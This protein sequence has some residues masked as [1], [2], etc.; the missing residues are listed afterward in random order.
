MAR[1]VRR[2]LA[3]RKATATV[4]LSTAVRYKL[5]RMLVKGAGF[6]IVPAWVVATFF[7]PSFRALTK[8]GYQKN[9][10]FFACVSALAFAFPEP[11]LMVYEDES[12]GAKPVPNHPIR[13][14]L[15]K[16]NPRMSERKLAVRTI[17]YLAIGGNC[18]LHKVRDRRG[19]V[20]ELWPYHTGQMWPVPGGPEW[21]KGYEFDDG[22]GNLQSVPIEDV[23]H[24]QWPSVDPLQPWVAQAPLMAAAREVDSDNETTRYLK[25]ILQ[26]DAVPRGVLEMPSDSALNPAEIN[27]V[28]N[29]FSERYGGDNR[30]QVLVLEGG[31]KYSRIALNLEELAFDAL[32]KIPETR[33]AAVMR[34]PAIVAGISAGLDR[35]TYANYSEARQVFTQDTLVPLWS[36]V[37]DEIQSGLAA[38]FGNGIALRHDLG[39]V[40]ALQKDMDKLWARVI[41]GFEKGIITDRNEARGLLG[42]PE[43]QEE[44]EESAQP[45]IFGYHIDSGTVSRNEV[46]ARLGLPPE[47]DSKDQL[48]RQL[49]GILVVVRAAVDTGMS[50]DAA[51]RLVGMDPAFAEG[52]D[53]PEPA[54]PRP[55][56]PAPE[57]EQEQTEPDQQ[58]AAPP[59]SLQHKG[60]ASAQRAAQK[61]QKIR[62]ELTRRMESS[63]DQFFADLA[64]SVVA[65]ASKTWTGALETKDDLPGLDQLI[66]DSDWLDLETLFK[67]YYAELLEASWET[68]NTSLGI[69]VA[70]ELTDPAVVKTLATAGRHIADIEQT[71]LDDIRSLLQYGAEQG[72]TIEQLARGDDTRP[73]LRGLVEETYKNRARTIARTELGTAQQQ[74]AVERFSAMKVEKVLVLD[75]GGD[76]PDEEC[77][78]LNNTV[79]TLAWA[80]ENPLAH[81]NCT[82][83]FA[84]HYDD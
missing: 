79:Q 18:M 31:V 5:A 76:D 10:A 80:S 6:P 83:C 2:A 44:Q 77:A 72:W 20:V 50:L 27:R 75:N 68:W 59:K 43:Q 69:D 37:G 17:S 25:A 66:E 40:Q 49:Q 62:R 12:E 81:P 35:A 52:S 67:R 84:P 21:V 13:K 24:L 4:R 28:K 8:E 53:E 42:L 16:P 29:Q 19:Q 15:R 58:P 54:A 51:L 39:Q 78:Q 57:E 30:G 7:D 41:R 34:V 11:P 38:E 74:C 23:I 61:L 36:I 63:V 45:E 46:R 48:L 1:C 56:L 26:N 82:R 70:F 47:D 9:A 65:R 64:D 73:G 71:T 60:R 33:I 32:H 14:L 22:E 3:G 55:A